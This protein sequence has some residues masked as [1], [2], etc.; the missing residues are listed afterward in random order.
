MTGLFSEVF[1]SALLFGAVT[2]AIPLLLAGLGEQIS[3]KAGVLNIG[4][5]GMMLAGAYLGFVGAFYSGSLWLG[6]L[7]GAVGGAAVALVMALLCVRIGLN[8]IVIGIALTLGLEG[9][10]AL[11]HHFQFS[12][13]YPRLP[14]A[15]AT[16]IPLLS[17]I[18]VIGPAFFKHHLIV[19]LAVALVFGMSYL[20]RRTQLGLNL[21]AA[22]DKPAALDVAGI[23]V[24]RT[25]TIAVLTTGALA[26]LGGAYLANV[27]A[28]LFIPF[29]TNGAGF[30]GI[31]LA[32][33]ARGRPIWV[34]F[35]ALLF[36]VCLSLTTAMQVAGIN[37]PTD[38]IQMLPFL[39]VMIMLVLFGRR[40]SLPAALGIP[41]ERGAR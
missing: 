23:D 36:G 5:E 22:G 19:Y 38:I 34:L 40:A 17:G 6:F 8:Q 32:M 14:A 27:G 20:Y 21:Q 15:D 28:G 30:L 29:I 13:S 41:Y 10:T 16:V 26:G 3:E 24:V 9:L 11:L 12:R 37:I 2:A 25:R 1:L 4:I 39:A 18:P 31:V 33:L 35:G 7:T